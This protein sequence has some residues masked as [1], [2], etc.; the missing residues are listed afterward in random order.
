MSRRLDPEDERILQAA[1]TGHCRCGGEMDPVSTHERD[2]SN[3]YWQCPR[4]HWRYADWLGQ[5]IVSQRESQD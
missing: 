2:S 5:Q 1:L 3:D 4:C